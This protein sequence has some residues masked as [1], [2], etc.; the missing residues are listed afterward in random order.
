MV[1]RIAV[2]V[3]L[4]AGLLAGMPAQARLS[5]PRDEVAGPRCSMPVARPTG[6]GASGSGVVFADLG[7]IEAAVGGVVRGQVTT[8][9]ANIPNR[10]SA[11]GFASSMR[12][13]A[14]QAPDFV[15]LNEVGA[16][17][18]PLLRTATPGYNAYRDPTVDKTR[19]GV[20]SMNNVV[21]W[22]TDRWRPLDAGRVKIVDDDPGFHHG[23][24]FTWDRYATW[25]ILQRVDGVVVPVISTHHMTNPEKFPRQ[26][27]NPP[28]TR[29]QR[30]ARG[31]DVL[32]DL[33]RRLSTHGPVF[34][35]GDMNSHPGQGAWTA[36]AKMTK[37]GYGRSKDR[38][39]MYIFSP[40]G[41]SRLA[42]RE[43]KVAS[44]HPALLATHDMA[45]TAGTGTADPVGT[46]PLW[47]EL[48]SGATLR[49]E[50]LTNARTL[51]DRGQL[52]GLPRR[53]WVVAVAA[54]LADSGMRNLTEGAA[55]GLF[56]QFPGTGWGTAEELV[57]PVRAADAFYG[58]HPD[59]ARP[60]LTDLD[61]QDL[62]LREAAAAVQAYPFPERYAERAAD[63]RYIVQRI[64]GGRLPG[65]D[66]CGVMTLGACP[67]TQLDDLEA[68]LTTAARM[69]LRCVD[70]AFPDV[71]S[72][73]ARAPAVTCDST[74][75]MAGLEILLPD[76]ALGHQVAAYLEARGDLLDVSSV[77]WAGETWSPD[78]PEA[79]WR[80]Y[81]PRSGPTTDPAVLHHDRVHV[82]LE[83]GAC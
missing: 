19:G 9:V 55:L 68:G 75:R 77:L 11:A 80:P 51:I 74:T 17:S 67:P 76:E 34:V 66:A 53:A 3:A 41:T 38:G 7:E 49:G 24:P 50:T 81:Q 1:W 23:R 40:P 22:R 32:L 61:W 79:G 60:G 83:R 69:L 6:V 12:T 28:I 18:L 70:E 46:P 36:D 44:D 59:V 72:Y 2:A 43:V 20:Q 5:A 57:D 15:V 10:T 30:Y 58:V 37:A 33:A 21:M 27:G 29:V 13:L 39:V 26:H 73:G 48:P 25:V 62:G 82:I 35:A 52:A 78:E 71:T 65:A 14:G 31:M 47:L 56:K 63:A 4:V 42:V 64:A 45:G 54:A 16:R 8:A